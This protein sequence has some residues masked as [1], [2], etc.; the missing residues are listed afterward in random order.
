MLE[1]QVMDY[2][3]GDSTEEREPLKRLTQDGR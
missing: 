3:E 2:I 1:S